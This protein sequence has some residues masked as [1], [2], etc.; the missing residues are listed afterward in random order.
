LRLTLNLKGVTNNP[1]ANPDHHL[2]FLLNGKDI[3]LVG[4]VAHDA[5]WEGQESYTWTSPQL[6]ASVLKGGKNTLTIQKVNDL[7]T[8]DGQ[9]VENQ[10][11][12]V[13]WVELDFPASY[14]AV[15]GTLAFGNAFA[16]SAGLRLFRLEGFP[17]RTLS[18]WDKQG[19]K[20]TNFLVTPS[21]AAWN[22]AFLD[23]L[24]GRTDYLAF[25]ESK[26]ERPEASLD[27][28]DDL[29]DQGQGADYLVITEAELL[30][31]ALDSL[32][33]FRAK[34][35]LRT[36]VVLARHIYQAFGDG[37]MDPAAIRRFVAY[38]RPTWCSSGMRA[39]ASRKPA[40]PSFP[41]IP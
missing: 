17:E 31:Q 14:K 25:A 26:R 19:R 12:F 9:L 6:D 34:Q 8:G 15:D 21:G 2:K 40:S 29:F 1:N 36:R 22:A 24:P 5:I 18:L 28:L 41:S 3:S 11:A 16:D 35:G 38:A 32:T 30:G 39:S 27:T 4:G 13:N 33:A 23:S 20:L 37:S 7:R 10:D